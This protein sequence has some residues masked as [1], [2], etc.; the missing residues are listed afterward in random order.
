MA[1]RSLVI[2]AIL[3][4]PTLVHAAPTALLDPSSPGLSMSWDDSTDPGAIDPAPN[5]YGR[6]RAQ[7]N[8]S[9]V[10][11]QLASTN[12]GYLRM[13]LTLPTSTD[14][15]TMS[16]SQDWVFSVEW[17]KGTGTYGNVFE[18]AAGTPSGTGG[19][20]DDMIK[21]HM[22]TGSSDFVL[23]GGN[24]GVDWVDLATVP[25]SSIVE[26]ETYLLTVHYEAA[27]GL[28]DFWVDDDLIAE[29][30]AGKVA[31]YDLS[32]VQ[33]AGGAS[34][35]NSDTYDNMRIGLLVPEPAS[36]A[37]VALGGLAIVARRRAQT[38]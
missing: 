20:P 26:G 17:T 30:V 18:L 33:L 36:L 19:P 14:R 22:P 4:S 27:D 31:A 38:R 23:Q 10:G 11:G 1:I 32:H 7:A 13:N 37:L 15:A 29:D 6:F 34:H 2:A 3:T 8:R 16:T 9:V 21:L 5:D 25:G 24:G 28:L 35:N 12:N